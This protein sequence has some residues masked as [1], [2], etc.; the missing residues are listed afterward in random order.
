MY[1]LCGIC[2]LCKTDSRGSG[3]VTKP[4]VAADITDSFVSVELGGAGISTHV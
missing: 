1:L 2:L 3:P 4:R